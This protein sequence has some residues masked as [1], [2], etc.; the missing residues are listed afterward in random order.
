MSS[1]ST[2]VFSHTVQSPIIQSKQSQNLSFLYQ[3]HTLISR[4]GENKA[5]ARTSS[6]SAYKMDTLYSGDYGPSAVDGCHCFCS[7]QCEVMPMISVL[8]SYQLGSGEAK[9]VS[10]TS[11]ND[12]QW[13]KITAVRYD[14]TLKALEYCKRFML[15]HTICNQQESQSVFLLLFSRK[16][17]SYI[18]PTFMPESPLTFY[19]Q[20]ILSHLSWTNFKKQLAQ[21][22]IWWC[23][24]MQID[25][26]W[27]KCHQCNQMAYR[28][29]NR[30]SVT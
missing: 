29:V 22:A 13:H 8:C 17:K 24:T 18:P 12:G 9:I 28:C 4:T 6:A 23:S 26:V 7:H 16:T 10:Q 2:V 19:M 11:I 25:T 20:Q 30:P 21:S 1:L 27:P 15:F 14:H 5:E 3:L